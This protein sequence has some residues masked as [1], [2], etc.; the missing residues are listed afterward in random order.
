MVRVCCA[1]G[2]QE[3]AL[4][5]V[6]EAQAGVAFASTRRTRSR[7]FLIL[8]ADAS[9]FGFLVLWFPTR[10]LPLIC[11]IAASGFLRLY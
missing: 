7:H 3:K 10:R 1:C 11:V 9:G 5:L 4:N 2:A 8:G 6:A